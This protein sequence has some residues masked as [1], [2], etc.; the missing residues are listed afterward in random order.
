MFKDIGDD[1]TKTS[2]SYYYNG[3]KIEVVPSMSCKPL[4]TNDTI[5]L[6]RHDLTD[7]LPDSFMRV[8]RRK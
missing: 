6:N 8:F 2:D 7:W 1:L 5:Y 3:C 4:D